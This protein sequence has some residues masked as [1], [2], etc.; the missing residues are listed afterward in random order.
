[1][2]NE[3]DLELRTRPNVYWLIL[4]I[5]GPVLLFVLI[6]AMTA[7]KSGMWQGAVINVGIIVAIEWALSRYRIAIIGNMLHYRESTD[8]RTKHVSI[9]DILSAEEGRWASG[10]VIYGAA[11][12][13]RLVITSKGSEF[14][15]LPMNITPLSDSDV[16]RLFAE[17]AKRGV[18]VVRLKQ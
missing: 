17:L 4:A 11:P 7:P 8:L 15:E 3:S 16:E 2:S 12:V 18:K 6:I 14:R 13:N 9:D 10:G 1:M 5:M